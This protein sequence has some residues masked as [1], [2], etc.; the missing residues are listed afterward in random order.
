MLEALQVLFGCH[1]GSGQQMLNGTLELRHCTM[2]VARLFPSWL[3]PAEGHV[4]C[5]VNANL[6]NQVLCSGADA[7]GGAGFGDAGGPLAGVA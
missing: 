1:S 2:P 4:Q 7:A 5:R 3:V 6:G